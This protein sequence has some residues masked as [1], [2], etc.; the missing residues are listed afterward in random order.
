MFQNSWVYQKIDHKETSS[1]ETV[2]KQASFKYI[3]QEKEWISLWKKRLALPTVGCASRLADSAME[4]VASTGLAPVVWAQ[5][6]ADNGMVKGNC[7]GWKENERESWQQ[8]K[9]MKLE[10]NDGS[11]LSNLY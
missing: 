1:V 9:N 6:L 4:K 8:G 11:S 2:P 5:T 10:K 3:S 7:F